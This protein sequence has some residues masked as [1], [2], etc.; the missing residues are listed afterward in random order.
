MALQDLLGLMV[1]LVVQDS[2][3]TSLAEVLLGLLVT[4]LRR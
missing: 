3:S 4:I 2:R 1:E